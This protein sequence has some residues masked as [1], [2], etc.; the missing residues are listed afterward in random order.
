[1]DGKPAAGFDSNK[2]RALLAYLAVEAARPH[3]REVLAEWLWPDLP[4]GSALSK[5]RFSLSNLRATIGDRTAQPSFLL[6]TNE[7]LQF[8]TASDFSLDAR[9]FWE[10][11]EPGQPPDIETLQ[12]AVALYRGP[13]MEGFAA[14]DSA[15]LEEWIAFKRELT[16][17]RMLNA[18][19]QLAEYFEGRG[20]YKQ[21]EQVAWRQVEL[22]PWLEEA[23]Q[24]LMRTLA[25]SG[26]RSAALAQY[27]SCRRILD[28][29]LGVAPSAATVALYERIRGGTWPAQPARLAAVPA[30]LRLDASPVQSEQPLFVAFESEL[31]RLDHFIDKALAGRGQVAFVTGEPGRGKTLL[32]QEFAA[33]ALAAHPDLIA[34]SGNCNAQTGVGDPY[35]PFLEILHMLTGDVEAQWAAGAIT[36]ACAQRLWALLPEVVPALVDEGPELLDRFVSGAALLARAQIGAPAQ[37]ARLD[38][39]LKRRTSY[40]DGAA[41]QQTDLFEQ[42]TKVLQ[43]LAR[44]HPLLLVVEDLQWADAGSINLLFHIGR[45]LAGQRILLVGTY[46]PSDAALGRDGQ[47][48]PLEPVVNELQRDY[49]DLCLDLAQPEDVQNV[50]VHE[51]AHKLD[52]RGGGADGAPPLPRSI[53]ARTWAR[54]FQAAFEHLSEVVDRD[55]TQALI[56]PYAATAPE[57]FF[58]VASEYHFLAPDLLQAAYPEV[59]RLT[60]CFYAGGK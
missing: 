6:I 52:A 50:V 37:A 48:H 53:D 15:A 54:E 7:T 25:L 47:R 1:V 26:Q 60:A 8:N 43:A 29:E 4:Q 5:L 13:F 27:E 16:S 56:D 41:V 10:G 49:G 58:A 2:V 31:A 3:S 12:E 42:V 30:F 33:R 34:V 55:E 14:G 46:R 45:R 40:S 22:E 20:A 51:I 32:V 19:R 24:Q 38:E 21:A 36:S 9:D 11:T 44:R 18:L 17:R 23:H 57:E 59:A 39:L 28:K 35:L